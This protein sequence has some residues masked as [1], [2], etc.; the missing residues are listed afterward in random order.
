VRPTSLHNRILPVDL[1][2]RWRFLILLSI[3]FLASFM[4]A[5]TEA[6]ESCPWMNEPTAAGFVGGD[7]TSTVTFAIKDKTDPNYSN[8]DKNDAICDFVHRQGSTVRTLRIEVETLAGTPGSFATYIARCGSLNTPVR[9]IG[10][11]AVACDIEG[12][13]NSISEQVVSRVRGRALTVRLTASAGSVD[14]DLLRQKARNVAEQV[15]G[16][17]F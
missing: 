5:A 4:A 1:P 14:R 16:F 3:L 13:K 12:K 11:E 10:N 9:A 17:L 6:K 2:I 7:V 8:V 15:A